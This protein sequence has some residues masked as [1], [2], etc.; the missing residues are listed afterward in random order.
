MK[1][2]RHKLV[3]RQVRRHLEK[4]MDKASPEVKASVQALCDAVS[5]AYFDFERDRSLLERSMELSSQELV[6]SNQKMRY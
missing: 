5:D 1:K 4:A 2:N 6:A 3:E